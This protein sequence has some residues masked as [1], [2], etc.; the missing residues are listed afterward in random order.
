[1]SH[2]RGH[3]LPP[4]VSSALV[5]ALVFSQI[6]YCISVYGN[7]TQKNFSRIQKM[8]NYAGKVMF[9]RKKFDHVSDLIQRLWWLSA[10][11]LAKYKT[12]SP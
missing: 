1:M 11:E 4:A 6:R 5:N 8:H 2:L 12:Q 7:G 3:V 9:R 10:E